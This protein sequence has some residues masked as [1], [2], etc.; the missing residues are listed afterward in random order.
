MIF[1]KM[2]MKISEN[3]CVLIVESDII[4]NIH[5]HDGT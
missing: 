5:N 2:M 4:Y 3:S 1:K